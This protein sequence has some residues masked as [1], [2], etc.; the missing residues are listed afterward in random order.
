[1]TKVIENGSVVTAVRRFKTFTI[2]GGARMSGNIRKLAAAILGLT[3]VAA[4]ALAGMLDID[5]TYGNA[6]GCLFEKTKNYG[7]ESVLVLT[8]D[9][10]ETFATSCEFLQVL[11]AKSGARVVTMLCGHEGDA[12]QT[13]EF[14]RVFKDPGGADAYDLYAETGEPRGRVER[15]AK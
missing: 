1:M 5:G 8:P 10:Y 11:P 15:C 4:P 6:A 3:L 7:D 13:I 12:A 14:M 9:S 2:A